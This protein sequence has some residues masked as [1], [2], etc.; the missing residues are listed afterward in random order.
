VGGIRSEASKI[1][2]GTKFSILKNLAN[3]KTDFFILSETKAQD[4]NL[5][6]RKINKLLL[7]LL[8]SQN[9]ASGGVFFRMH[10]TSYYKTAKENQE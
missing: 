9:T 1:T 2:R 3:S 8:T 5:Q 4:Y 7:T 10:N 6:N